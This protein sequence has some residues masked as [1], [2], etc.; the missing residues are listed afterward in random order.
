MERSGNR[1][2]WLKTARGIVDCRTLF[3][4]IPSDVEYPNFRA[5]LK[6]IE[7]RDISLTDVVITAAA[8]MGKSQWMEAYGGGRRRPLNYQGELYPEALGEYTS[9]RS[10]LRRIGR[11]SDRQLINSRYRR[12]WD[13]DDAL[14][15]PPQEADQPGYIYLITDMV[16]KLSYVG[17]SVNAP[18]I[19]WGQH[20]RSSI[21]GSNAYLHRA[22]RETGAE[23]F[24][25]E[26]LEEVD[27]DG[28][29]AAREVHWILEL[30]TLW[31]DGYNNREGGQLG[32]YD[33]IPV[34]WEGRDFPSIAAMCREVGKETGLPVHVVESR[35]RSGEPLPDQA[36]SHSDHP[37]AGSPL[38]RQWLGIKKRAAMTYADIVDEWLDYDTWKEDTA[39]LAGEG[40]LT[41]IDETRA[42]GPENCVRL[43]HREIVRRTHGK[44]FRAFDRT[45]ATKQDA[46]DE[47]GIPRNVFDLR[48]KSGMSVEEALTCPI[49]PTSKVVITVDDE[50]FE[51]RN[52]A[53]ETLSQRYGMTPD[54]V[55]D[56]LLR[57][58]PTDEWPK[59]GVHVRSGSGVPVSYEV[60]GKVYTS[61]AELC[62]AFDIPSGT[63]QK[64]RRNGMTVKNA[65]LTPVKDTSISIFGYRWPSAKAACAAFGLPH[66]TYRTRAGKLEMSPEDALMTSTRRGY[67]GMTHDAAIALCIT[68]GLTKFDNDNGQA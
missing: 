14:R 48:T 29:L 16:T 30:D 50:E 68:K 59:H 58:V 45:W 5:R 33:G 8:H 39:S 65:L 42:W 46:L 15:E 61:E 66:S 31:P 53:C 4:S 10:F 56:Y 67:R 19:R 49:G 24:R 54:Q 41:R 18:H 20:R 1:R 3:D 21:E 38:F 27:P 43:D 13:L 36:R 17:L 25:V 12:Q 32:G 6:S 40:R 22:I 47:Y 57:G 44:A 51:S 62:R 11:Y 23:K 34:T 9:L 55:K 2:T 60:D 52:K 64:R 63:F 7:A 28:D 26:I 37:E 35:Y